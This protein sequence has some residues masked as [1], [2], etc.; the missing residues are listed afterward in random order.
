MRCIWLLVCLTSTA[1]AASPTTPDWQARVGVQ[2]LRWFGGYGS[3]EL[4]G[5]TDSAGRFRAAM[6]DTHLKPARLVWGAAG[7]GD[8]G[9][10]YVVARLGYAGRELAVQACERSGGC[11]V[12][13]L[14]GHTGRLVWREPGRYVGQQ[15]FTI[16]IASPSSHSVVLRNLA[17]G[18]RTAQT[19]FVWQ[20]IER[21]TGRGP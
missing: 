3:F 14:D 20:V 2:H 21:L 13:G 4:V 9:G 6:E 5:G 7:L 17:T 10:S 11:Q 16:R 15:E 12:I 1:L 8:A 19:P 18:K